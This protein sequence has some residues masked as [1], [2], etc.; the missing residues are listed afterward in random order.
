MQVV[1][2][3]R[4]IDMSNYWAFLLT[5]ETVALFFDRREN[6]RL[7]LKCP[8]VVT[9]LFHSYFFTYSLNWATVSTVDVLHT[10][11]GFEWTA[12]ISTVEATVLFFDVV[13]RGEVEMSTK[14]LPESFLA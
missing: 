7:S 5:V 2:G 6:L 13:S 1:V 9:V 10:G 14:N 11:H 12:P 8:G 4:S 3:T